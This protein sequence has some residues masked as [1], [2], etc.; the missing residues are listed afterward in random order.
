MTYISH[1]GWA[2]VHLA[3]D[4]AGDL[5]GELIGPARRGEA[6]VPDVVV[7]VEVGILDPVRVIE[8]EGHLD[9]A[10]AHRFE[11]AEQRV[12]PFV[13]RLVRVE[14]GRRA[15]VDRQAV[16]VAVRVRRLHVEETGVEAAQLLHRQSLA[17]AGRVGY[18]GD[19]PGAGVASRT[20]TRREEGRERD[21]PT[22]N[23]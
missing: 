13:G 17:P 4:D 16:D 22:T 9:E 23:G 6:E 1:S 12:E 7:E 2:A 3:A 19:T 18:N 20:F 10:A 11:P 5:L 21:G 14:V 8:L 15:L